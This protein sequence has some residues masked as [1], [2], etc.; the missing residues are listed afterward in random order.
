MTEAVE[1]ERWGSF[2]RELC[3]RVLFT[4]SCVMYFTHM[5]NNRVHKTL[6]AAAQSLAK[7][8]NYAKFY[9]LDLED[10]ESTVETPSGSF[11]PESIISTMKSPNSTRVHI[12]RKEAVSKVTAAAATFNSVIES[13]VKIS[14][15]MQNTFQYPEACHEALLSY[16]RKNLNDSS[17][18]DTLAYALKCRAAS[19]R[20]FAFSKGDGASYTVDGTTVHCFLKGDKIS[21][22]LLGIEVGDIVNDSYDY[23]ITSTSNLSFSVKNSGLS[24]VT[25]VS[26]PLVEAELSATAL[27][28]FVASYKPIVVSEVNNASDFT[29]L[30]QQMLDRV[31]DVDSGLTPAL[32]SNLGL[33]LNTGKSILPTVKSRIPQFSK[34]QRDFAVKTL[35]LAKNRGFDLIEYM[36]RNYRIQDCL[37]TI[38]EKSLHS[39]AVDMGTLL[40][41]FVVNTRKAL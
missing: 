26:S 15:G 8:L 36:L 17:P 28:A 34:Q 40:S 3:S 29:E 4:P 13:I 1:Q 14:F 41:T 30:L 35:D 5:A 22:K 37:I 32:Y 9:F 38:D 20:K 16:A 23:E 11:D 24:T 25:T 31:R 19:Y 27:R 7:S 10:R 6:Y 12:T 21:P 2:H 33:T 18:K 39:L